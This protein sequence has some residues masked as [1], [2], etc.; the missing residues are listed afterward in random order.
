MGYISNTRI[1]RDLKL[2]DEIVFI[3]NYNLIKIYS[4]AKK[5]KSNHNE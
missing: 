1:I 3:K 2:I 4:D 5:S